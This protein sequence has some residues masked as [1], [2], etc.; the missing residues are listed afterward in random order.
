MKT[1]F[2]R[3]WSKVDQS[4]ECWLWTACQDGA[5]YG[6]LKVNRK[7]RKVHR[8]SYELNVGPIPQGL[9]IDHKCYNRACVKPDHLH[10]VTPKENGENRAGANPNSKSGVRGVFWRERDSRWVA[11]I[12]VR[13][14]TL[15]VGTFMTKSEATAAVIAARNEL[16]T[17]NRADWTEGES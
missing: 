7:M 3:F 4:G 2:E 14:K 15:H 16:H 6:M 10:A 9:W 13:E 12:R 1:V 11:Q 17:N 5:G 8:L